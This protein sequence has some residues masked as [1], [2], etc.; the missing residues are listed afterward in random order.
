[1]GG[2][3]PKSRRI[4]PNI[5]T[6]ESTI[7]VLRNPPWESRV[8]TVYGLD[9]AAWGSFGVIGLLFQGLQFTGFRAQALFEFKGLSLNTQP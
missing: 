4:S 3:L 7:E 9:F 2:I 6:L 1:M 8:S 5:E